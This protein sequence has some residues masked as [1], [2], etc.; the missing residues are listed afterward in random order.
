M[1]L[2]KFNAVAVALLLAAAPVAPQ[3]VQSCDTF[4]PGPVSPHQLPGYFPPP[5]NVDTSTLDNTEAAI[6][7]TLALYPLAIDGRVFS[8]LANIFAPDAVANYSAPIGVLT[9][10]DEIASS[11]EVATAS[12]LGTQHLLGT[13]N[14]RV[15]KEGKK[16]I[17][18]AYY[19]A[20]HFLAQN[21]TVGP[22][23]IVGFNSVLYAYGQYQDTWEKRGGDWK[24]VYRNLVYMVSFLLSLNQSLPSI[25]VAQGPFVTELSTDQERGWTEME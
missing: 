2:E 19:T 5:R 12:F 15:C 9:G 21:G 20:I 1:Y 22:G 13:T 11:L 25:N 23:D 7:R 8:S 6:R 16:A 17:S 3:D 4:A 14:I 18:V 24:I 10:P